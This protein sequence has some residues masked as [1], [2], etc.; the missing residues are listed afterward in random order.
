MAS[1]RLQVRCS[2]EHLLHRHS[3]TERPRRRGLATTT[4]RGSA[5]LAPRAGALLRS[6]VADLAGR[7]WHAKIWISEHVLGQVLVGCSDQ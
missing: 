7:G 4:E 6:P 1:V 3:L 2:L 5:R